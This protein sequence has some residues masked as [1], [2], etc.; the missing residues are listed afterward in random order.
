MKINRQ[1][2]YKF[3]KKFLYKIILILLILYQYNNISIN[4]KYKEIDSSNITIDDIEK[5][6]YNF[7]QNIKDLNKETQNNNIINNTKDITINNTIDLR[8]ILDSYI[9]TYYKEIDLR[10]LYAN[11][12]NDIIEKNNKTIENSNNDIKETTNNIEKKTLFN[13][14]KAKDLDDKKKHKSLGLVELD[15]TTDN[16]KY[17]VNKFIDNIN[18]SKLNK[19]YKGNE[20]NNKLQNLNESNNINSN[21][22]ELLINASKEFVYMLKQFYDTKNRLK[23]IKTD[24]QNKDLLI[25]QKEDIINKLQF[26]I[27]FLDVINKS[28]ESNS[29]KLR[30][31]LNKKL[32]YM[33]KTNKYTKLKT[34]NNNN[35][36][37]DNDNNNNDNKYTEL[38]IEK[39]HEIEN[40]INLIKKSK[41][42]QLELEEVNQ[43][44]YNL[45]LKKSSLKST[46]NNELK[47]NNNL[48]ESIY[49][50]I[51]NIKK[52]IKEEEFKRLSL[53][54]NQIKLNKDNEKKIKH[55]LL[56][57][58]KL[59]LKYKKD[60]FRNN[61]TN[62]NLKLMNDLLFDN[63]IVDL[64][65][66]IN[67]NLI[68][69][70]N[71]KIMQNN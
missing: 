17:Q 18:N 57:L 58:N 7:I 65:S 30:D 35:N 1:Y 9:K 2:Y 5:K 22:I 49:K 68:E 21:N 12:L 69:E 24:L 62:N 20:Y 56:I 25:K 44:T 33:E 23:D 70:I 48:Y 19:I 14:L 45:M 39:K 46:Y 34:F 67:Y 38:T 52:E 13:Q 15:S 32:Y 55:L 16:Y 3:R 28:I 60:N 8:P 4:N 27:K 61:N 50:T 26:E 66:G 71:N 40:K 47:V 29:K 43:E 51:D 11:Y 36:N 37:N 41:Q 31:L 54:D 42:L 10:K 59:L 6:V 53:V 64:Q 63:N